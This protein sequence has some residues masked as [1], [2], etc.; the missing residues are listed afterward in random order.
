M[1]EPR[2]K[3]AV[4]A[5]GQPNAWQ[6][7][8]RFAPA[9]WPHRR[10]LGLALACTLL[11]AAMTL[12]APWPVKYI[13]DHALGG[14]PL[15]APLAAVLDGHPARVVIIVLGAA[16]ALVAAL[17]AL[18]S[19]LEKNIEARVRERMTVEL[20]DRVLG[21][22]QSLSTHY[23]TRD[24]TGELALRL[25]DDV[26]QVVRLLTKSA[27]VALR[28]IVTSLFIF[29]MMF[30]LDVALGA[31]G[32]GIALALVG[33]ARFHARALRDAT[34]RKRNGEGGVAALAQEILRGQ[35]S[36]QALGAEQAMRERFGSENRES[37]EA[38]VAETRAAVAME[39]SLQIGNGLA[40][41]L[42][43]VGGGL[44]VLD[45]TLTVGDLTIFLAYVAQ[46]LKPIEKMNDLAGATARG[47]AR[48]EKLLQLLARPPAVVDAPDAA[49][50]PRA[51]GLIEMRGVSFAYPADDA[52][53][54]E[55]PVLERI[56]LRLAPGSFTVLMGPSGAGKST[57]LH[58]LLRIIE[59]TAGEIAI[60]GVPYARVK[61]ASLRAQFAVM[62][63]ETHLFA[64][65]LR[66]ALQP[67]QAASDARLWRAL[68]Q[69]GLEDTVR[70]LPGALDARLG[71]AGVNLSG[72][73]RA[74]LSLAR[75]LLL[76][77]PILLLD[78][79][80]ANVD[81]ESQR[82][83][84]DALKRSS[85]GRTCLGV[86]H[87]PALA[88]IADR[89]LCLDA[90]GLRAASWAARHGQVAEARS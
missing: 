6:V 40:I 13:I 32:L 63:Q 54:A 68:A 85:A 30:R 19:A 56:D 89:V 14:M 38:G 72:G 64:G 20:R 18:C 3:S 88:Q 46:L 50:L 53:D 70:A 86:S 69:V 62:L 11:A 87:Q 81:D 75:A 90:R 36:V 80:L 51:R 57:L 22:I 42:M 10:A 35:P 41:A 60:D 24:R 82:I 33:L 83:I 84:V 67:A 37:L 73:Q 39:R 9:L 47:V 25:V 29:V 52:D 2:R 7:L 28:H 31:L 77:R 58:L 71:E 49:A 55:R 45:G 8:A 4:P 78:E 12:L 48:G 59:P 15:P 79:P 66:S 23:R 26:N 43:A 16:T 74:R 27:P 65:T 17:G 76:D 34:R 5:D 61:L 1:S 21:H 44:S